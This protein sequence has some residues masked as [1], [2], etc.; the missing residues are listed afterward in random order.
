VRAI[1]N[2]EYLFVVI[3]KE[4]GLRPPGGETPA[5]DESVLNDKLMKLIGHLL[6]LVLLHALR[7]QILNRLNLK[8]TMLSDVSAP[9]GSGESVH[10]SRE[11]YCE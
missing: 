11:H 2:D 9:S 8:L 10:L 4:Y 5:V 1:D 3:Q 7:V 6:G